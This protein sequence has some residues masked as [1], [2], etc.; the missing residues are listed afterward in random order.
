MS[1]D[2]KYGVRALRSAGSI[3]GAKVAWCKNLDESV[4]LFDD[5]KSAD[6]RAG[7]LN[8]KNTPNCWYTATLYDG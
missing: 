4:E 7:E 8:G 6:L 3:F 5:L 1:Q 2:Q